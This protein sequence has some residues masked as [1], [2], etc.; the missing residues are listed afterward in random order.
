MHAFECENSR[1]SRSGERWLVQLNPDGS[2]P[3]HT[4]GPKTFP[5]LDHYSM[6]AQRAREDLQILDLQSTHPE[7]TRKQIIEMLGG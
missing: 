5:K 2:I 6:S 3:Q 7:L 1:C 4:E